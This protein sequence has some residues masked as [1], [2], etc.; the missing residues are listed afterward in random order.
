MRRRFRSGLIGLA[1]LL[2]GSF[3]RLPA[4]DAARELEGA[5][6]LAVRHETEDPRRIAMDSVALARIIA[7]Q[8]GQPYSTPKIR[9]SIER[10]FA[11]GRFADIRVDAVREAGGVVLTFLTRGRYFLGAVFVRGVPAPPSESQ[12]R[13]AT[14]LQLG[15]PFSEEELPTAIEGLRRALESEGYFQ[16]DI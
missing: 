11:T 3:E 6:V 15:Q 16:A 7:Q 5:P 14:R 13:A 8:P 1:V 10:L 9:E 2:A 4:Q 12:L